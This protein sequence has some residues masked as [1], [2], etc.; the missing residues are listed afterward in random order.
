LTARIYL[1]YYYVMRTPPKKLTPLKQV[2]LASKKSQKEFADLAG[3][4]YDLY[5]SLELGRVGLT[6]ANAYKIYLATG[7][8][9]SSLDPSRSTR[10][11]YANEPGDPYSEKA[12]AAWQRAKPIIEGAVSTQMKDL[13]GWTHFLCDVAARNGKAW[14]VHTEL[15]QALAD[16]ATNLGL[17]KAIADALKRLVIITPVRYQYGELRRNPALAAAVGFKDSNRRH[18][19]TPTNKDWWTRTLV[20]PARWDPFGRLPETVAAKLSSLTPPTNH[21][22]SQK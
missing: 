18:G 6:E 12:W 17:D 15:T 20:D 7:V 22:K 9:P 11:M 8:E 13:I 19:K 10:A 14:E 5:Q 3:I 2:R 1:T 16:C 21:K 4:K